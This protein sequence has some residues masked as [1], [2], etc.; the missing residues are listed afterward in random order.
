MIEYSKVITSLATVISDL[1]SCQNAIAAES[2]AH[3]ENTATAFSRIKSEH[4]TIQDQ[5][6]S[7]FDRLNK[8]SEKG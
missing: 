3:N 5:L 4:K 1:K 2:R 7:I 6:G 8:L